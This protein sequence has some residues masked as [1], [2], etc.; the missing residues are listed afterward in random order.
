[1][2]LTFTD[3]AEQKPMVIF[4]V[5]EACAVPLVSEVICH[6]L[7]V[8]KA[9]RSKALFRATWKTCM[10]LDDPVHEQTSFNKCAC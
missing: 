7:N 10:K 3:L 8:N 6:S 5:S 4:L 1:M 9:L 2:K